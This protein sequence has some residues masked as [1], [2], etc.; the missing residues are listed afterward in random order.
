MNTGPD[1]EHWSL[2][3]VMGESQVKKTLSL[4]EKWPCLTFLNALFPWIKWKVTWKKCL[5]TGT[6]HADSKAYVTWNHLAEATALGFQEGK[7]TY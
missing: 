7:V 5:L 3:N 4:K 6:L 2:S 1:R